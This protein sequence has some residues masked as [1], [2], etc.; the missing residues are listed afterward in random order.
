MPHAQIN[1]TEIFYRIVGTGWPCFVL[2]GGLGLDH[3]YLHPWL[4]P[5]G[6][7]LQLIYY[8]QRTLWASAVH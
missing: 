3:T 2:H 4:N 5:L 8:D 7:Q 1:S 6:D